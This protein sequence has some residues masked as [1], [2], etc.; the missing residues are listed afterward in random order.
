[1][2]VDGL[3]AD[4]DERVEVA[5]KASNASRSP[6]RAIVTSS[7]TTPPLLVRL[8]PLDQEL[9]LCRLAARTVE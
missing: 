7:S 6:S 8:H 4:D 9:S 5:C 2:E 1:M 3:G